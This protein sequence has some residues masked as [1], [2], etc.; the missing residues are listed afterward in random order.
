MKYQQQDIKLQSVLPV[1]TGYIQ[2]QNKLSVV[3]YITQHL[4][5][6]LWFVRAGLLPEHDG[7][8]LW[9]LSV[10][11]RLFFPLHAKYT[12]LFSVKAFYSIFIIFFYVI[13]K[14]MVQIFN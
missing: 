10:N 14:H 12:L 8:Y 1:F 6:V 5:V 3:M 4:Q 7:K 9:F 11:V 2:L 13:I